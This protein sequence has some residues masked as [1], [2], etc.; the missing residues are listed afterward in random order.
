MIN[1]YFSS[2]YWIMSF[3]STQRNFLISNWAEVNSFSL[4]VAQ[5]LAFLWIEC[6]ISVEEN[7]EKVQHEYCGLY[8]ESSLSFQ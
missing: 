7:Y 8:K 6:S 4:N 5:Y 3:K 1:N 2:V